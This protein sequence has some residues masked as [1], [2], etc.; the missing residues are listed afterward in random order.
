MT[1]LSSYVNAQQLPI[2]FSDSNDNF[3][4]FLGS[5]FTIGTDPTDFSN[6]VGQCENYGFDNWEGFFI[7]LSQPVDLT[8]QNSISLSFY[9]FDSNPH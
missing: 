5:S 4:P 9:A 8:F 1:V 2:D 6:D 3:T 7:D